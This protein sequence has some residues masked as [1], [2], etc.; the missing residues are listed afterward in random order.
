MFRSSDSYQLELPVRVRIAVA[1]LVEPM[2]AIGEPSAERHG[3]L[4]GLAPVTEVCL[5]LTG[6]LADLAE[7]SHFGANVVTTLLADGE[8]QRRKDA[9][10]GRREDRLDSELL[11]ERAG[12]KRPG[13]AEGHKR[14]VTRVSSALD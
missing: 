2:K 4:E 10:R 14:E 12:V 7:R 13:A 5:A 8:A 9:G 11:R 1:P 3:Q 6:K